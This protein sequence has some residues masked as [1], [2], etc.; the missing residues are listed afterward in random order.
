[1]CSGLLH[2]FN[3]LLKLSNVYSIIVTNKDLNELSTLF[4]YNLVLKLIFRNTL[5][6]LIMCKTS[7]KLVLKK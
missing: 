3:F 1:M 4:S 7:G 2:D 6:Y 5:N